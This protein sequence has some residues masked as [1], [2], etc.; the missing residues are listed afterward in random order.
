MFPIHPLVAAILVVAV[1]V[2]V[3]IARVFK[4]VSEWGYIF[5]TVVCAITVIW[6]LGVYYR[7][8]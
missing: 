3:S 7:V 1:W 4:Q 8:M 2:F 5:L 6:I